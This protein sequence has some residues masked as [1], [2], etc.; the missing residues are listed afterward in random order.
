MI[1]GTVLM[2]VLQRCHKRW[3]QQREEPTMGSMRLAGDWATSSTRPSTRSV[4]GR[5]GRSNTMQE[6]QDPGSSRDGGAS[7]TSSSSTREVEFD[8]Q[9]SMVRE[10]KEFMG[11]DHLDQEE[12]REEPPNQTDRPLEQRLQISLTGRRRRFALEPPWEVWFAESSHAFTEGENAGDCGKPTGSKG[13]RFVGV[14]N[15]PHE[16]RMAW[17]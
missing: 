1:L 13:I 14:A 16:G 6:H 11:G 12:P 8:L 3:N 15:R 4:G 17:R 5:S 9:S 2:K 7:R 10:L